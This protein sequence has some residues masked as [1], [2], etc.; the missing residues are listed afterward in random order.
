[1]VCLARRIGR[2]CGGVAAVEFAMVLPLLMLM[3]FG[4]IEVSHYLL[5]REKLESAATQMLDIVNQGNNVDALSLDNLFST[6]PD[7]MDPYMPGHPH[8][9]IT[10]IIRPVPQVVG[11]VCKPIAVWQYTLGSS[12]IA[13]TM[14]QP[15]E[16]GEIVM[17]AGDNVMAIEVFV[18]YVPFFNNAFSRS[19]LGG[20][21]RMYTVSYEHGRYGSFNIDPNNGRAVSTPCRT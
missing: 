13:P 11:Q 15:A 12:K 4:I 5:F 9:V 18:D 2:E 3:L 21:Q 16:T 19:L 1:M 7:M 17:P 14:G 10:Q 8:V 20:A 6:L